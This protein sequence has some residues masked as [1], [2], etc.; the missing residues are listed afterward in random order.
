LGWNFLSLEI[1]VVGKTNEEG[2]AQMLFSQKGQKQKEG[3]V[4]VGKMW[5][6]GVGKIS[7]QHGT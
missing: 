6:G 2:V 7:N 4:G 3:P 5:G 1:L